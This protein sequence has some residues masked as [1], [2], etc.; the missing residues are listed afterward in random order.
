MMN[1]K[2]TTLIFDCFGVVCDPVPNGW[3]QDNRLNKGYRDDNLKNVFEQ[4]DLGKIG[5]ADILDYFLG[6]EGVTLTKDE[7][8][9]QIDDYLRID[10]ELATIILG[11]KKRGYKTALLTNANSAFF[12]RKVYKAIPNF[13]NLF[14]E[15]IISSDIGIT[16]PDPR[17]YKHALEKLQSEPHESLFVDDSP[18]NVE[19]AESLGINGFHYVGFDSF[20]KFL[21]SLNI[22]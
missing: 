13:K 21:R 9:K 16:K 8:R 5:E 19:A 4:F 22:V 2:I 18:I 3:F 20:V 7:M 6:Y 10:T 12:E 1:Q 15:I 11:F 14:N 17:I